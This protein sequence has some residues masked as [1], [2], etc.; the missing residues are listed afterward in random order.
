MAGWNSS[1][2]DVEETS[3]VEVRHDILHPESSSS[4]SKG[5][6][7]HHHHRNHPDDHQETGESDPYIYEGLVTIKMITIT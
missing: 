5:D 2:L 3:A 7:D 4:I 1:Q 6:S